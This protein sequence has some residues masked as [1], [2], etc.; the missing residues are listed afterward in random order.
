MTG[1]YNQEMS[2]EEIEALIVKQFKNKDKKLD[3]KI[4]LKNQRLDHLRN[5]NYRARASHAQGFSE[6][7]ET[8]NLFL[9]AVEEFKKDLLK[10]RSSQLAISAHQ[11]KYD[12]NNTPQSKTPE[13]AKRLSQSVL[14]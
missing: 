11:P 2:I 10:R 7:A 6:K 12:T 13:A 4:K 5:F 14:T 1:L 8:E 3:R 9:D